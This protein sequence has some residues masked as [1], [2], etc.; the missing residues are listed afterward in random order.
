MGEA[1][2]IFQA[3]LKLRYVWD[4]PLSRRAME[5][6]E[7]T[8]TALKHLNDSLLLPDDDL[9]RLL[10]L[11]VERI[12][13]STRQTEDPK[14]EPGLKALAAALATLLLE[15][16][17][18]D[19]SGRDVLDLLEN[20]VDE[21]R[22]ERLVKK[23]EDSKARLRLMLGSIGSCFT[24]INDVHWTLDYVVKGSYRE[25]HGEPR[26][27]SVSRD[28]WGK[29]LNSFATLKNCKIWLASSKMLVEVLRNLHRPK[30]WWCPYTTFAYKS[31]YIYC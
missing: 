25:C 6:S 1:Y 26:L 14:E 5:L 3:C 22:A 17:K 13:K 29:R 11:V 2:I 19:A 24:Q 8:K 20:L 21:P 18:R 31:C 9:N 16:A 4:E 12:T 15:A 30:I 7:D 10:D 27:P 28:R 23:Y